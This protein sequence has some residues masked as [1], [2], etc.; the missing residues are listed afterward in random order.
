M[1]VKVGKWVFIFCFLHGFLSAILIH[2][3][4]ADDRDRLGSCGA[5][6]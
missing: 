4:V 3:G 2:E 6:H 1:H 5:R